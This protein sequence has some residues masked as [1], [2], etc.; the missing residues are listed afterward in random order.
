[1]CRRSVWVQK[2]LISCWE[3]SLR[4]KISMWRF[5]FE[6]L[7]LQC[8]ILGRMQWSPGHCWESLCWS[9]CCLVWMVGR[10]PLDPATKWRA[11]CFS[12]VKPLLFLCFRK[13]RW[14]GFACSI[15]RRLSP[16]GVV[17]LIR[18]L[19]GHNTRRKL[20]SLWP[21]RPGSGLSIRGD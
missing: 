8:Q 13:P 5:F 9:D 19:L 7:G 1:M 12:C 21:C 18:F 15:K 17:G 14:S 16:G 11:A 10:L 20:A 3:E 6:L 2:S 4:K